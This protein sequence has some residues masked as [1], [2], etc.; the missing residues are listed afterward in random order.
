MRTWLSLIIVVALAAIAQAQP[1]AQWRL[2]DQPHAD[3]PFELDLLVEGFDE[4][5]PPVQPKLELPG[6]TV[7]PMG[8]TPSTQRSIQIVNGRRVDS[9]RV[10][11][12]MRW[13]VIVHKAG[14]LRIPGVTVAQGTKQAISRSGD[15][16]VDTVPTT[17]DMKLELQLPGRPVFVGETVPVK[18]VWMFRAQP[19]EQTFSIPM[20][21]SE[22]FTASGP[23]VP[24]PRKALTF[25]AG[26]KDLQLPYEIDDATVGGT[27]FK[28]LTTT[29]YIA[30][31]TIPAGGKVEL[32]PASVVAALAVGRPDFFGNSSTR[33]FRAFD[34]ARTLEV[35]ALPET[36]KPASFAGAVGEQYS[37]EV[38]TSRS[39][40]Q[41]GEPVELAITVK[42]DQRLDT[43][44]LGKLDGD[45]GLPRDRFEVPAE[46]P[47]G[48]LSADG[49]VKTFKV[50]AQVTGP[51][52][53]VPAI[54]FSYFDPKLA[55]YRTIR[56]EPIALSVKGGSVVGASDVVSTSPTK[57]VEQTT[58]D[59][60]IAQLALSAPDHVDDRP[61]GGTLLWLLV[62]LLYAIPSACSSRGAGSCGPPTARGGRRVRAARRRA[63]EL[64]D[65]AVSTRARESLAAASALRELARVLG[66]EVDDR[67]LLARLETES[68]APEAAAQ[69]FSPDLRSD[70]A[71]LLRRWVGEA[72]RTRSKRVAAAASLLVLAAFTSDAS[73]DVLEDG[74]AAYRDA[75]ELTS[76]PTG[77]KAAFARAAVALEEAS[78]PTP[79]A[80]SGSPISATPRSAREMSPARRSPIA[81]PSRSTRPAAARARTSRGCAAASP[82]ASV[83]SRPPVRPTR[84]CSSI[85]GRARSGSSSGPP[86]S[87]SASCSSC[88]GPAGAVAASPRWPPCRLPSGWRCSARSCSRIVT[89]RMRWCATPSSSARRTARVLPRCSR[90]RCPAARRS[91][92]SS[93]ADPGTRSRS[94]AAPPGGCPTARSRRCCAEHARSRQQVT[95]RWRRA[96]LATLVLLAL[97]AA[98]PR[99]FLRIV[100]GS[101]RT[102]PARP[103]HNPAVRS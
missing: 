61:L 46:P 68:F 45:G 26:T 102:N 63:E 79:I 23:P 69:P 40:V 14:A 90:N 83:R 80:P 75:M 22:A 74:R 62:G 98:C 35:K 101:H 29:F 87:R 55:A 36:D 59:A 18:L 13:R 30:P 42:S 27:R 81:A 48:E 38:R 53:E 103:S 84:C 49:K 31:R 100:R 12:V 57:R 88:R 78:A 32:P 82:T 9:V 21:S 37:I 10:T 16:E 43:L 54:A 86:R 95:I 8:V 25:A 5:P 71:G 70:A 2:E 85:A 58:D 89:P 47:T 44:A 76:D 15:V 50:V 91:S 96:S 11:W 3:V 94:P 99:R 77:R 24:D 64:L 56:S 6:A 92:C 4:A 20:L 41:L 65:R 33:L 66:R 52:T 72:R 73:A 7:T 28:R 34:V 39:V 17:E 1:A 93:G 19:Q 67:G 97:L 60:V 51:A